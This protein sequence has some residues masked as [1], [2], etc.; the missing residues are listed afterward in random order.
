ML[1]ADKIH[2]TTHSFQ[3]LDM[4]NGLIEKLFLGHIGQNNHVHI[5]FTRRL[6]ALDD[7]LDTNTSITHN[8]SNARQHSSLIKRRKANIKAGFYILNIQDILALNA[9][10]TH[11]SAG[12]QDS[13]LDPIVRATSTIS[14]ITEDAVGSEPAPGP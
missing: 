6:L 13:G 3:F 11:P 7:R 1:D 9:D 10:G 5:R 8:L 12:T 14:A 4:L 2:A